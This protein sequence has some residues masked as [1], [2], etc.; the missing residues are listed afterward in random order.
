MPA[1]RMLAQR[2]GYRQLL[3][4]VVLRALAAA[5]TGPKVG[6]GKLERSG[7]VTAPDIGT[8]V[9]PIGERVTPP[10]AP[11]VAAAA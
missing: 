9:A 8:V 6:W 7:S 2:F 11:Q 3:Y 1:F 10:A 5:M 4:A